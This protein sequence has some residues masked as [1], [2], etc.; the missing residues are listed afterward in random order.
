[1]LLAKAQGRA[2]PASSQRWCGGDD[3]LVA[4]EM[5]VVNFWID[6]VII[7]K[8]SGKSLKNDHAQ[9]IYPERCLLGFQVRMSYP[10]VMARNGAILLGLLT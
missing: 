2:A 5:G 10:L 9:L 8:I 7:V 1:M 6:S 3:A 4:P